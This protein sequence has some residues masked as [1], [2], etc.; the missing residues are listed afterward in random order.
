MPIKELIDK[1]TEVVG[2]QTQLAERIGMRQQ[3]ISGVRNGRRTISLERRIAL[4]EIADYDLKVAAMEDVIDRLD[5]NDPTQAEIATQLK[6]V[7]DA[8]P[9]AGWRKR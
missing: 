4:A 7:I 1:A 3:D 6:A 5:T 8:F 9:N 2:T